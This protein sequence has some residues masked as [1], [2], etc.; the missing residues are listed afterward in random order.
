[1]AD[2]GTAQGGAF[3][4]RDSRRGGWGL[5]P[6]REV[7]RL[8]HTYAVVGARTGVSFPARSSFRTLPRHGWFQAVADDRAAPATDLFSFN[9]LAVARVAVV[10][11]GTRRIGHCSSIGDFAVVSLFDLARRLYAFVGST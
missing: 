11:R 10:F 6:Q 8:S 2:T 4:R 7:A 5:Q 3:L 9:F 1:M